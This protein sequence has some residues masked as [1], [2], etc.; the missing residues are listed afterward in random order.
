[1]HCGVFFATSH[2]K[3]PCDGI[4]GTVKRKMTQASLQR[5][6]NEQILTFDAVRTFCQSSIDGIT[7][8]SISKD[9]MVKISEDLEERYRLGQTV[10]G[11]R[12]LHHFEP[13]SASVVKAKYLSAA[14]SF[15][16]THS[17][18]MSEEEILTNMVSSLKPNDYITCKYDNFWW[19][20]LVTKIYQDEKDVTCKFMHP[21]GHTFGESKCTKAIIQFRK[22]IFFVEDRD[23]KYSECLSKVYVGTNFLKVLTEIRKNNMKN[24]AFIASSINSF[25]FVWT[26]FHRF[27]YFLD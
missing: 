11:T 15:S 25:C 20:A 1:M 3:S 16:V 4:G 2:G 9:D 10:E 27:V 22:A 23:R 18:D 14:K 13:E 7:F 19:L 26:K 5:P 24:W 8:F 6:L 21:H 12:S 17:F